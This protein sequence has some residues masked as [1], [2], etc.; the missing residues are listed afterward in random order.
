MDS[1]H[2]LTVFTP[3]YNRGYCLEVLFR[4]LISQTNRNFEWIIVDDDST[5]DTALLVESFINSSDFVIKYIKQNHGGKHRAINR[6]IKQAS[7]DYFFIVDSDDSLV[8]EAVG[9][10]LDWVAEIE[11]KDEFCGVSGLRITHNGDIIGLPLCKKYI[12]ATNFEREKYGLIGDKAEVYKTDILRDTPFPEFDNE[13][14]VTEAVVFDKIASTGMKIRWHNTPIYICDYQEDGLTKNGAND[15]IGHLKN[16]NGYLY[17]INQCKIIMSRYKFAVYFSDYDKTANSK[18]LSVKQRSQELNTTIVGY[19][20]MKI[21]ER[22]FFLLVRKVFN[23][24]RR[25]V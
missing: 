3:T 2:F 8:P 12:D 1:S 21:I 5:D 16:Y 24:V 10:V 22:P 18:G 13:Y 15:I 7:G 4:S 14:F 25:I 19:L 23:N 17:Y 11:G 6:G 9:L 20:Y